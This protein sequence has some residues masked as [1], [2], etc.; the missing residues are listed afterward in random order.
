[1]AKARTTSSYL[2]PPLPKKKAARTVSLQ[3]LPP[4]PPEKPN[5]SSPTRPNTNSFKKN[6]KPKPQP[7]EPNVRP[8]KLPLKR[9]PKRPNPDP[10]IRLL[11]HVAEQT[12][13]I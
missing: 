6:A 7:A 5:P 9:N 10:T 13:T 1:M 3:P 8:K 11:L 2:G 12:H 4:Q